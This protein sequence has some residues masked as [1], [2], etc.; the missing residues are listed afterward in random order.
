MV[1]KKKSEKGRGGLVFAL[2]AVGAGVGPGAGVGVRAGVGFR[3]GFGV[4]GGL[5]VVCGVGAVGGVGGSIGAYSGH[6]PP[7][8]LPLIPDSSN[9]L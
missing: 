5:G 7:S 4:G 1:Q 3:A 8:I 2:R 6:S 9:A